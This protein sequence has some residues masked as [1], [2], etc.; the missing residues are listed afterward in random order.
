VKVGKDYKPVDNRSRSSNVKTEL[1][2]LVLGAI[3]P[4]RTFVLDAFCG[5]GGL[6]E[7]V[8]CRAAGYTGID[9]KLTW[10]PRFRRFVG[11]NRR[12]MR[13]IDLQPFNVFDLDAWGSPWTQAI[14][15]AKRRSWQ[16]GERG[17]IV[18]TDGGSMNTRF[19]NMP[20]DMEI[21]LKMNSSPSSVDL[22]VTLHERC[23]LSWS[24]MAGVKLEQVKTANSKGA[25]SR[26][27]SQLMIYTAAT[28]AGV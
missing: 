7:S 13:A 19:G 1:R 4:E 21:L 18:M 24:R 23:L 2:S 11:D 17:A 15:I 26:A 20:R 6:W 12:I 5:D 27:G 22:H 9:Q 3:G 25:G 16:R 28:F 10:P 14:T 8:W